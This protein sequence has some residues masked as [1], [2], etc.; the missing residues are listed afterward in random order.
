MILKTLSFLSHLVHDQTFT[1][2]CQSILLSTRS[3]FDYYM[4]LKETAILNSAAEV[5]DFVNNQYF[6]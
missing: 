3:N 6:F 2:D 5:N 4:S 1:S